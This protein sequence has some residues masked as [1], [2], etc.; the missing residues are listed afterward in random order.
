MPIEQ[1]QHEPGCQCGSEPSTGPAP[2]DVDDLWQP[3]V[4]IAGSVRGALQ[5]PPT[6]AVLRP[7]VGLRLTFHASCADPSW[8]GR[9]A[10]SSR[11]QAQVRVGPS[12][13]DRGG[14][15]PAAK[16]R[17]VGCTRRVP[18][19][20]DSHPASACKLHVACKQRLRLIGKHIDRQARYQ[21]AKNAHFPHLPPSVRELP[22]PVM[23]PCV[24]GSPGRSAMGRPGETRR[25]GCSA[26][27]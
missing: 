4:A 11:P 22:K 1:M 18:M 14:R 17:V 20:S 6:I 21:G 9:R 5:P 25:S 23:R 19:H 12:R 15:R 10:T 27:P 8:P 7:E 16:G 3:A 13:L 24:G 2:R 26:N